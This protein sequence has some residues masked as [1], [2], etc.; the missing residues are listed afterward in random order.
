MTTNPSETNRKTSKIV[1]LGIISLLMFSMLSV[2]G[3]INAGRM[4]GGG[5]M[6]GSGGGG[7]GGGGCGGGSTV[8]DSPPGQA[9][10]DPVTLTDLNEDPSI[11]EYNIEAKVSTVNINGVQASLMTYNGQYPGPTILVKQ[12][13]TLRIHFKNS[14]PETTD[15]NILGFVKGVTNVHTHGFHVSPE[16]PA[17]AAH[18]H[19]MPGETYDYEYDTSMHPAGTL[20]FYHNHI[21]GLTAEQ[22]WAGLV[23]CLV[24]A[25]ENS[26]LAGYETH[27]MVV[28]DITLSGNTPEPYSS[29]MDYMK[30][31]EGSIVMVNGQ[32]NP[33]LSMRPGQVQR[34][35]ILNACNAR[36]L[37]LNLQQHGLQIIG[38]DGGLLDKPYPISEILLAPGERI[39]VLVKAIQSTG[40]Y[41][42]RSLPHDRGC[43][44]A[45]Q[46]VTLMTV[47]VKGTP[48]SGSIP[49]VIN[50][51]AERWSMDTSSLPKRSLVLSMMHGRGYING[52]DFDVDPYTIMSTVGTYEVWTVS[53]QG[54]MD[55]PFHF[56]VNHAQVLSVSGGDAGYASLYT[57]SPALKDTILVPKWGSVTLLVQVSDYT[58]MT[59]FHCHIVE[60][61]DIGMMGMWHIMPGDME[62][63]SGPG[64]AQ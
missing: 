18:I 62:P 32:V 54:G 10:K 17:D 21:H 27:I 31:K 6:G 43:G 55:H 5:G 46:T 14:L 47:S 33:V 44:S 59:M 52:M 42:L 12:G 28:K 49:T 2:T 20:S 8:I 11:A 39:D 38:T 40:S 57:K 58:G 16:E 26:V 35:R 29:T 13:D 51:D 30:G 23:G 19:I 3:V 36:F 37:K 9:F 60:H 45:L 4:G 22:Y 1:A 24:T 50:P 25:D 34:W 63:M 48:V 41:K 56:H 53:V 15:T 61:E 7:G 64:M